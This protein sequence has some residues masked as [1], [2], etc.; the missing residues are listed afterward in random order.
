MATSNSPYPRWKQLI[1]QSI[2]DG[3]ANKEKGICET[4]CQIGAK[5]LQY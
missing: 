3:M 4:M 5:D 2:K 1:S